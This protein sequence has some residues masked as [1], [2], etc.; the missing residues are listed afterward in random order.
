MVAGD[1]HGVVH[2]AHAV[3]QLVLLGA[4]ELHAAEDGGVVVDVVEQRAGAPVHEPAHV[5]AEPHA[6]APV[7][8]LH[9]RFFDGVHAGVQ[10]AYGVA[11][12]YVAQEAHGIAAVV[13]L[14]VGGGVDEGHIV[15]KGEVDILLPEGLGGEALYPVE[16]FILVAVL[17]VELLRGLAE[18]GGEYAVHVGKGVRVHLFKLL[19]APAF[20]VHAAKD[21][22]GAAQLDVHGAVDG[23]GVGGHVGLRE[24]ALGHQAVLLYQGG[25]HV[26]LAAVL[27]AGGHDVVDQPVVLVQVQGLHYGIQEVV[28]LFQ[29]VVVGDE[30]L[31]QLE[32]LHVQLFVGDLA[33]QVQRREQ[34][35]AARVHLVGHG[36]GLQLVIEY[37]HAFGGLAVV[38]YHF[39]QVLFAHCQL[40]GPQGG[41]G[42]VRGVHLLEPVG[43]NDHA[44][45]PI[46][47]CWDYSIK[48][49]RAGLRK[50]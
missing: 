4:P 17:E 38:E 27:H 2:G 14:V 18:G 33:E 3:V 24:N 12:D 19:F 46:I 6:L 45:P 34:P 41:V 8:C 49:G 11:F 1:G 21:R 16:V 20:P 42:P 15:I 23:A 44:A 22:G 10:V 28:G 9:H 40:G 37:E 36:Q 5:G 29:L 31:G 13:G 48:R 7:D 35:A 26:P 43:T 32:L 50:S 39:V 25:H 30:V 47:R